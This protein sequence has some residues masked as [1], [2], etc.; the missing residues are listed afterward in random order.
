MKRILITI[1]TIL[2]ALS[3]LAGCAAQEPNRGIIDGIVY[4]SSDIGLTFIAPGGWKYLTE[5]EISE[6]SENG[7]DLASAVSGTH[8]S[9]EVK[10]KQ[11]IYDMVA[12]EAETGTS[13]AVAYYDLATFPGG[14]D[15]TAEDLFGL[16]RKSMETLSPKDIKIVFGE[17]TDAEIGSNTYKVMPVTFEIPGFSI[18]QYHYVRR[19]GGYMLDVMATVAGGDDDIDSVM[20]NFS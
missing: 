15:Y 4:A 14:N 13:V 3:L 9:K 17:Y 7:A 1:I 20:A 5:E 12:V 16:I 19:T 2:L 18:S 10:E 11:L 6:M 8:I